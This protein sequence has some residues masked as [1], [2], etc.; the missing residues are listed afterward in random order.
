MPKSGSDIFTYLNVV[1]TP[2]SLGSTVST[3]VYCGRENVQRI[4]L[5]S[6]CR[7][8]VNCPWLAKG[9]KRSTNRQMQYC[10]ILLLFMAGSFLQFVNLFLQ[11]NHVQGQF[12]H[13]L[14]KHFVHL[15]HAH[16]FLFHLG[17]GGDSGQVAVLLDV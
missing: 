12:L 6:A 5:E 17:G 7:T 13:F 9:G 16:A 10:M 15:A 1:R 8:D 2:Y 14:Q 4:V 3:I 11:F